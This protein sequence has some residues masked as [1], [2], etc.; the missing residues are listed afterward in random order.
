M[1][2]MKRTIILTEEQ[3]NTILN[4]K[5]ITVLWL[6]DMRDPNKYL[7]KKAD[8]ESGALYNNL[9][10]YQKFKEEYNPEFVWVKT[11]EE[12]TNYILKN[13]VPEFVSFD[14][15]LGKGL[16]KGAECALWLK[17]YCRENNK[18]L[19]K[20]YAHSANPNGRREITD[21]MI[22]E[23]VDNTVKS[24][25][26]DV[27]ADRSTIRGRKNKTINLTYKKHS[28]KNVGNLTSTDMLGTEKMEK[29]DEDTYVIKLKG[30]I[31]S[32]NITSIKGEEVMHYFKRKFAKKSTPTT[33]NANGV[34]YELDMEDS[35][36]AEFINT[37]NTKVSRVI[38]YCIQE[39]RKENREYVPSKVSI[40]PVPSSENFNEEMAKVMSK[41]S[42]AGLPVQVIDSR[43]LKKDLRNLQKDEDF[44]NKNKEFF[45]GRMA[46]NSDVNGYDKP[47]ISHLEDNIRK[48]GAFN[49]AIKYVDVMNS[50]FNK[51]LVSWNNFKVNN[52]QKTLQTL[53]SAYAKYYD[54]LKACTNLVSYK[55]F[56][57]N[58][59]QDTYFKMKTIANAIK[60]TKGRSVEDRSGKIWALVAPILGKQISPSTGK[61]YSQVDINEWTPNK[62]QIK[63]L[64]NGERMGL[65]NYYNQNEDLEFVQKELERIKGGVF[66]IFDDNISGGATLS[67][68]CYQCKEMGIEYI[69]PITFGEMA[70]KWT[71]NMIPLSKPTNNK[72]KYGE[73]NY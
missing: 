48:L 51:I 21:A 68:I 12:F 66:V 49:E 4:R 72:G 63:N 5:P 53:A 7:N 15:D 39:F 57:R 33:L 17:Q 19:P 11:F 36:F 9:S 70:Q 42:L 22:S 44:I 24:I 8:K 37:F 13:G 59:G 50:A 67:D 41:M 14:H 31:K 43:I 35:E 6:D 18:Q 25:M 2:L 56:T 38:N 61:E 47:V 73:F 29:N 16:K 60:Y 45:N 20:F 62:F 52:S 30:G 64:S 54:A 40:Y 23:A 1:C 55:N 65:K 26:E 28:N 46:P 32:Y 27:F 71:M 58:N 69:I 10:F 3:I 34:T